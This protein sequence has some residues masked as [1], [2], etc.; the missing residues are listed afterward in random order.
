MLK[1]K[2]K[3][4][5]CQKKTLR[6]SLIKQKDEEDG[7]DEIKLKKLEGQSRKSTINLTG[8]P[9]KWKEKLE[10]KQSSERQYKKVAYI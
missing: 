9:E 8:L 4:K 2:I 1:L 6:K 5:K 7:K 10:R 3:S